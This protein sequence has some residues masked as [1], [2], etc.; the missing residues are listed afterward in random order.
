MSLRNYPINPDADLF[1]VIKAV[2]LTMETQGYEANIQMI[3]PQTGVL[4]VKKDRDGFTNVLGMGLECR[5][6]FASIN[7]QLTVN[8]DSEWT[9]KIIAV[10]VGWFV[11]FV[12]VITGV[13]G[14]VNQLSLPDKIF[15]AINM[16]VSTAQPGYQQ[17]PEM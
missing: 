6:N 1:S 14:A 3:S 16:N 9:N 4:T 12:P 13:V 5:V 15:T 10:A 7:G 11:C 8:I 17:P 2:A